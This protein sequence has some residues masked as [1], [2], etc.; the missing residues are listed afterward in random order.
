MLDLNKPL[1]N[2][3]YEI[4]QTPE[5]KDGEVDYSLVLFKIHKTPWKE[6]IVLASNIKLDGRKNTMSFSYHASDTTG[7]LAEV[8]DEL[9]HF[10]AAVMEDII[11]TQLANG[12][13]EFDGQDSNN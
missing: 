9:S 13:I 4:L 6:F 8:T 10:V 7:E 12:G 5:N 1:E 2:I 11:R 3:D